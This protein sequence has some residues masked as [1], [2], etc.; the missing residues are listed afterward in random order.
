MRIKLILILKCRQLYTMESITLS[1][2]INEWLPD[3]I[4]KK[5]FHYASEINDYPRVFKI[6]G[7]RYSVK[8]TNYLGNFLPFRDKGFK[9]ENLSHS[10][11][12]QCVYLSKKMKTFMNK[13]DISHMRH[14]GKLEINK[15]NGQ[16]NIID[17]KCLDLESI[18]YFEYTNITEL[19]TFSY[20]LYTRQAEEVW[21]YHEPYENG[22]LR[23]YNIHN[24]RVSPI[25]L[26]TS[27]LQMLWQ[28]YYGHVSIE[29]L[30]EL[31]RVNQIRERSKLKTRKDFIKAFMKL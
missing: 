30:T 12:L 22:A 6:G 19:E 7:N 29:T 8:S 13:S 10:P 21:V 27:P 1:K 25:L 18:Q 3:H 23:K 9:K 17:S 20:G 11:R 28:I 4:K 16:V 26:A 15:Q 14:V 24:N 31:S 2:F 5:I